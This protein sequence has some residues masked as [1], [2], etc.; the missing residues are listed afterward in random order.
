MKIL[1]LFVVVALLLAA[2]AYA[3][4]KLSFIRDAEI[5]DYLRTISHPIFEAAGIPP[6]SISFAMVQDPGLNAFVAGG[7][8][9]YVYTGLLEQAEDPLQLLGVL[10]HETG[11]ISGGHLVRGRMAMEQ[12]S[13]QAVL[14]MILGV[15]AGIA[16]GNA[17]AGTAIIGGGQDLALRGFLAHSRVQES[18]ADAAGMSFLDSARLPSSG[19]LQFMEKLKDQELL[20]TDRQVEYVRTHPLTQD[21]IDALQN[22]VAGSPYSKNAVPPGW[23]ESHKR[24]QAKL[25]GFMDPMRALQKYDADDK[26]F[27]GRYA[28]AVALFK[29]NQLGAALPVVDGLLVE[30]PQNAYLHELRGQ[31]LFESSRVKEAVPSYARAVGLAPGSSL[32]RTSYAHALLESG[33]PGAIATAVEQLQES[34][35]IEEK[36]P[37]TWRLLATAWGRQGHE[38]L[39]AYALA[40]EA[41]SGGNL[42]AAEAQVARAEK[43]L[44]ANDPYRLRLLDLKASLKR[45]KNEDS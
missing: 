42:K 39:S 18:S 13:A 25:L 41:V 30:E 7:M 6:S 43:L 1:R 15:A 28:R 44:S 35:R 34:L 21:R 10:A 14:A 27:A 26:T 33:D 17:E 38:G 8:N 19:L 45:A 2:P 9:I 36:S 29:R 31:M 3:Q 32:I 23:T 12:A 37:F 40:E 22:H 24:M 20:P 16:G 11:H 5:E 4:Q